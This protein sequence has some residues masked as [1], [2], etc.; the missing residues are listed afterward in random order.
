ELLAGAGL[1]EDEDAGR[2][3][4]RPDRPGHRGAKGRIATTQGLEGTLPVPGRRA[5]GDE[6][7]LADREQV[8]RR[9]LGHLD[10]V[11]VEERAVLAAPVAYEQPSVA[12]LEGAVSLGRERV[13]DDDLAA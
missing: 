10:A 1:T 2:G 6:H 5:E 4:G 7:G 9:E 13:R 3:R 12:T 11:A 8:A